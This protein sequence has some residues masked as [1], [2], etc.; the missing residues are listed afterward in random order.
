MKRAGEILPHATRRSLFSGGN[1]PKESCSQRDLHSSRPLWCPLPH[2][3]QS[4]ALNH[5]VIY[6]PNRKNKQL[7]NHSLDLRETKVKVTLS[8]NS[9][10][11]N[12]R[13]A[14]LVGTQIVVDGSTGYYFHQ[15]SSQWMVTSALIDNWREESFASQSVLLG[16]PLQSSLHSKLSTTDICFSPLNMIACQERWCVISPHAV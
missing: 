2:C 3:S 6:L 9:K 15:N 11:I 8:S 5:W 1:T 10:S 7:F 16:H 12:H 14:C 4:G 13:F